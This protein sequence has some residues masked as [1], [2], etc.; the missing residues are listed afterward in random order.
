MNR[1]EINWDFQLARTISVS[2]ACVLLEIIFLILP[3]LS[4]ISP[5]DVS[6]DDDI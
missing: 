2:H 6:V 1:P 5:P 4:H 3:G